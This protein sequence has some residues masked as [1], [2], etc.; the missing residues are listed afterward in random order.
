[1]IKKIFFFLFGLPA[2]LFAEQTIT[3]LDK[4]NDR[5]LSPATVHF[6][7]LETKKVVVNKTNK[8]GR[9]AIPFQGKIA[10]F[11]RFVGYDQIIDTIDGSK[12][13][14]YKMNPTAIML[15]EIVT[16]G[17]FSPQSI[18]NSV[19]PVQIINEER[20]VT[21]AASNLRELLMT[22]LNMRITQDNILGSAISIN[23]ISGNNV[24]I[25]VDGVPII[26]RLQ[27]NI[28]LSQINMKNIKKV[29]IIEG[30]M[31]TIYGTDALGGVINL[32]TEDPDKC[33]RLEIEGG[34]YYESVYMANFDLGARFNLLDKH[35]FIVSGARNFFGGF[36]VVDT[37]RHKEWKPK[38]QYQAD[39]KYG[40]EVGNFKIRYQTRFFNEY[41]LNRG[42]RLP[43]YYENAL[44]DEYR[45]NRLSNSLFLNGKIGNYQYLDFMT[46][47]SYYQRRKNTYF[48]DLT[49]LKGIMT[50]NPEDQDTNV[51]DNWIIRTNYSWDNPYNFISL[52]VGTE[53]NYETAKGRRIENEYQDVGDYAAFLSLN[54]R[55]FEELQIQPG[56]RFIYNTDYDA[57]VVPSVNLKFNLMNNLAFRAAYAKGFR[58]PSLRELYYFFVDVNHNIWGNK[59]LKAET[60]DSWNAS[61]DYKFILEQSLINLTTRFFYNDISNLVDFALVNNE[62][63]LYSYIN[64]GK[65]KSIGGEISSNYYSPDFSANFGFSYIGRYNNLTESSDTP[66]FTYSPELQA[67]F[68]YRL[69][70]AEFVQISAYFKHTGKMPRYGIII[71]D[72]NKESIVLYETESYNMLDLTSTLSFFEND[73]IIQFGAKNLFDIKKIEQSRNVVQGAHISGATVLPIGWGR[74]W[75]VST[76]FN[77][78]RFIGN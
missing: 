13:Y 52:Q 71:D 21:Q 19:F 15:Q 1:M 20:I 67:N 34:G 76:K 50:T 32:I 40:T 6:T 57:P 35:N 66:E 23:G 43:F 48:M 30:P 41:I 37:S 77:L 53:I 63:S 18:Q 56:I 14:T 8:Q 60:S 59:N 64:I 42:P 26:G 31:S 2:I 65:N 36:S 10:L 70:F 17:Q 39:L 72:T 16:T 25:M 55:P 9:V 61:L 51:F 69:P 4:V 47:Y 3:I 22:Q 24:K 27:G 12:N 44:D 49:T 5:P 45:T 33:R 62:S 73:L 38:I 78:N 29:E 28:D 58:A 68:T 54:Y 46:D 74:T 7:S 11:V 75:F